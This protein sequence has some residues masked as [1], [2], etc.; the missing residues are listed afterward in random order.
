M[1]KTQQQENNLIKKCASVHEVVEK[2]EL[3]YTASENVKWCSCCGKVWWFL[4]KLNIN[5][6]YDPEIPFLGKHPEE[7][8]A[9]RRIEICT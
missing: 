3:T 5:L 6:P 2:L 1:C 9:R 7:M 8:K 4:R